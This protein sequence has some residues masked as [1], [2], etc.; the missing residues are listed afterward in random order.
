MNGNW[1]G[2][3]PK[4]QQMLDNQCLCRPGCFESRSSLPLRLWSK[5]LDSTGTTN[6]ADYPPKFVAMYAIVSW[7]RVPQAEIRGSP[8]ATN[9][10][11]AET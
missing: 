10:S 5:E 1:D 8:E 9:R 6:K 7:P 11:E 3:L 4:S 2:S